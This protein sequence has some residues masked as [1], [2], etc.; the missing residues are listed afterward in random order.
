[1]ADEP[2]AVSPDPIPVAPVVGEAAA[3]R[4]RGDLDTFGAPV[5]GEAAAQRSR[6][7]ND[8]VEGEPPPLSVHDRIAALE[9]QVASLTARLRHWL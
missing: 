6:V 2:V 7:I 3:Q 9:A 8:E 4:S 1:M 5:V